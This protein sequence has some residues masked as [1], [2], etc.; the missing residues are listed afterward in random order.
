MF[1]SAWHFLPSSFPL[2]QFICGGR[3]STSNLDIIRFLYILCICPLLGLIHTMALLQKL[4]HITDFRGSPFLSNLLP[5]ASSAFAVQL[6]FGLP[7]VARHTEFLYDFSGGLTFLLTLSSS[8][9]A[10]ALRR[11]VKLDKIDAEN[12][13][14]TWNWR[15][16][17]LTGSVLVYALRCKSHSAQRMGYITD[18]MMHQ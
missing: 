13:L 9:L 4:L 17:A 5:A 12:A 6:L 10:P 18:P 14:D 15:Q 7:S 2:S 3:S 16:L 8:L 1:Q 11:G